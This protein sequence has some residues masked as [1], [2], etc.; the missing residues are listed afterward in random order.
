[1]ADFVD[2]FGTQNLT[3][4]DMSGALNRLTTI[5]REHRIV[6][7]PN[8]SIL[9]RVLIM[10]EGTGRYITPNFSLMEVMEPYEAEV[11][12]R[13]YSPSRMAAKLRRRYREFDRLLDTLPSDITDIVAR[14]REG[15]FDVKLEHLRADVTVNRV[16]YGILIAALYLGSSQLWAAETAPTLYGVSVVGATGCV[17]A[18]LLGARLIHAIHQ[19]G[20]LVEKK[21]DLD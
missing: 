1:V 7:P 17:T 15:R 20:D 8:V 21:R 16:V 5:I 12:S 19:S 3:E 14:L 4:F 2:E 13:R 6:L 18:V 9:L 11:T 10:L